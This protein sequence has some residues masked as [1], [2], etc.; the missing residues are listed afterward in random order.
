MPDM[1]DQNSFVFISAQGQGGGFRPFLTVI[2]Q[3][4][5]SG[6][7]KPGCALAGRSLSGFSE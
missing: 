5:A 2:N 7:Q 1:P 6:R 4:G 3:H